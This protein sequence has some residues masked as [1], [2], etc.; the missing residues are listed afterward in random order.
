MFDHDRIPKSFQACFVPSSCLR[1]SYV[2]RSDRIPKAKV[3]SFTQTITF[4]S[5]ICPENSLRV[6][7]IV[8]PAKFHRAYQVLYHLNKQHSMLLINRQSGIKLISPQPERCRTSSKRFRAVRNSST[9]PFF[10][11]SSSPSEAHLSG[12]HR[13]T[14]SLLIHTFSPFK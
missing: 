1:C 4:A 8:G 13:L 3:R 9:L 7:G 11:Y 6:P 12:W 10:R 2:T 5:W 14:T